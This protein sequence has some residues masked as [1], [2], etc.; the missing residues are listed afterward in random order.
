[1]NKFI[2]IKSMDI[3]VEIKNFGKIKDAKLNLRD[4]TV[5]AGHNDTGKSYVSR[6]LYSIMHSLEK[7]PYESYYERALDDFYE[8][9]SKVARK[10]FFLEGTVSPDGTILF[11]EYEDEDEYED[12]FEDEYRDGGKWVRLHS[13]E[14]LIENFLEKS[15]M[16]TKPRVSDLLRSHK[17][18]SG[19]DI[20]KSSDSRIERVAELVGSLIVE[21]EEVLVESIKRRLDDHYDPSML[22]NNK[23]YFDQLK[24]CFSV[25]KESINKDQKK[26]ELVKRGYT[27][28][29]KDSLRD[30]FQVREI[31]T[32][33]GT[34]RK[35]NASVSIRFDQ[36]N[37]ILVSIEQDGKIVLTG[38]VT[39]S[40]L[41][42]SFRNLIYLESPIFWK[43]KNPLIQLDRLES[44]YSRI[45]NR[46]LFGVPEYFYDTAYSI[47]REVVQD[48]KEAEGLKI[49]LAD[50]KHLIGGELRIDPLDKRVKFFKT[51]A[52]DTE[53]NVEGRQQQLRPADAPPVE[54]LP[55]LLVATGILQLGMIGLMIK[56]GFVAKGTVLFIDEP[57]AH[58]HT[59]WQEKFMEILFALVK[60]GV[61]I[62]MATHSPVMMQKLEILYKDADKPKPKV[63]LNLFSPSGSFD[64]TQKSF[65]KNIDDIADNLEQSAYEMYI[66]RL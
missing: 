40:S 39:H 49:L 26:E 21:Q 64:C 51:E 8:N 27:Y 54:G 2:I 30:N 60:Y 46:G 55:P 4:L 1:M 32:L 41:F 10:P 58:L 57:E 16:A 63:S 25:L 11:D 3:Q 14:R 7:D 37:Q 19:N 65:E 13:V 15:V 6:V 38:N 48:A 50:L 56:N 9:V 33:V 5:F 24:K 53:S 35:S 20:E 18:N 31:V 44:R 45:G 47:E 22:D 23:K 61:N 42:H 28:Y 36:E 12:V 66:S 62:V 43:L 29:I 34:D 59:G 17:K 52:E